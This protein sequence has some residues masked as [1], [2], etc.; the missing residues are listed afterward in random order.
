M[1]IVPAAEA[2]TRAPFIEIDKLD[3]ASPAIWAVTYFE[4]QNIDPNR[5]RARLMDVA[6]R[7]GGIVNPYPGGGVL[8]GERVDRL[9]K[10]IAIAREIDTAESTEFRRHELPEGTDADAAA[11]TLR[12]LFDNGARFAPAPGGKA[13]IARIRPHQHEEVTKAIKAMKE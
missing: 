8:I 7:E 9:R 12:G 10:M 6:T 13:I 4:C 3:D 1:F 11:F 5:M 2:V